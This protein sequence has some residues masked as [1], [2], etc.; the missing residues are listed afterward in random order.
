MPGTLE[1]RT[2][3]V[4]GGSRGVG[5][6]IALKLAAEGADVAVSHTHSPGSATAATEV[7]TAVH[8]LGRRARA[9]ASDQGDTTAVEALIGTVVKDFGR[10]DILVNSAGVFIAGEV[11]P[12]GLD[13]AASARQID[14]NYTGVIA[15]TR[16]AAAHLPEGGRIVNIG[17]NAATGRIGFNGLGEYVASKAAVAAYSRGAA[18]DLA[19]RGITVNVVQPGAINTRMNPE[20]TEWGA[21]LGA[22]IPAGRYGRPEEVAALVAFLAG[23]DAAYINGSVINI[24]GGMDA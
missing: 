7:V 5:A 15:A 22:T 14:V 13:P 12:D 1:G 11:G 21:A 6:A 19:G 8:R 3:L 23:P 18:R 10:L 16:A 9:Y 17:T 2:A 20:D 4:T 24:D